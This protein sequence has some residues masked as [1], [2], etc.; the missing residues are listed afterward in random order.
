MAI[1]PHTDAQRI[2]AGCPGGE[3]DSRR[4]QACRGPLLR[5]LRA[6]RFDRG[7]CR[8]KASPGGAESSPMTFV[9]GAHAPT[10]CKKDFDRRVDGG[11]S[12]HATI[13]PSSFRCN[14]SDFRART[15][16]GKDDISVKRFFLPQ[17]TSR[18]RRTRRRVRLIFG[19]AAV[20][21]NSSGVFDRLSLS[22]KRV[23]G[24]DFPPRLPA[25]FGLKGKHFR[26]KNR[27][28]SVL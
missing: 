6:A 11:A 1:L 27:K 24:E 8:K 20:L 25:S 14:R 7:C 2:L 26:L 10:A 12:S 5:C 4:T 18:T 23:D 13:T 9:P 19:R 3:R 16:Q 21:S 22:K 17:K 28:E 15:L